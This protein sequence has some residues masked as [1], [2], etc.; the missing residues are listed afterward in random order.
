MLKKL[1]IG[2]LRWV[3]IAAGALA[4]LVLQALLDAV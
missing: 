4:L 1:A 2:A 3:G